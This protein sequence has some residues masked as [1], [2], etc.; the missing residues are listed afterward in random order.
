MKKLYLIIILVLT[1]N[2]SQKK[3]DKR[4]AEFESILGE[5]QT[6]ALDNL[7]LD[8]EKNLIEI[9]PNLTIEKVYCQYLIDIKSD[10]ITKWKKFQFQ[11]KKTTVEYYKSGLHDEIYKKDSTFLE[12]NNLGKYMTALYKIKNTDTLIKKYWK[13]REAAGILPNTM[14]VDGILYHNPDFKNYFHKRIVV[15][16]FSF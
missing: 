14:F 2:C 12:A 5:R 16:E 8:F 13:I 9:Y 15:V 10:T 3:T 11:S 1:L 6:K 7:V 4:I